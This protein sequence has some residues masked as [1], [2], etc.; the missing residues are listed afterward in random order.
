MILKSLPLT[1]SIVLL[2]T[3]PLP[4]A[5]DGGDQAGRG[6]RM[7]FEVMDK[8]RDGSISRQEWRGSD[9]SFEV[10]DWNKD[11]QLS[12]PEVEVGGRRETPVEQADHQ[13]NRFERNVNWT[14]AGFTSLD[15]NRD[16]RLSA[17]E[18]H[19][20]QE[21]FRRVDRNRDGALSQ[22]EFVGSATED[23]DRG[24]SFDDLDDNNNGRV[25]RSEWHGGAEVF[26]RL[27]RNRDGSLSRFEVVGAEPAATDVW[28]QFGNLDSNRN[29]TLS[30]NEW[31]WS[32]GNFDQ[33]DANRDAV[34]SR[35]EFE[36]NPPHAAATNTA[37]QTIRVNARNR[38]TDGVIEVR[39]GDTIVFESSGTIV[40]SDNQ[41]DTATPAGSRS[42][43]RA[44]D[45]PMLNQSAGALIAKIGDY[46]PLLVGARQTL[47]A[48]V[49]GRLY[50]GVNDD[51]LLDNS[52]EFT[53]SVKVHAT[54]ITRD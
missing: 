31:H 32:L 19:F 15:H 20:D 27:D 22:A 28:D 18:W 53:V 5:A 44:P 38:W 17:N 46:G 45:A 33:R 37:A 11:G 2:A 1:V 23:D 52:G 21:T 43:R 8:N 42:A 54:N 10:H 30:R 9:R 4:S 36:S 3:T 47:V 50:F 29:G 16:R 40:M 48:P 25:E 7:R 13:P 14:A 24:D 34:L 49:G 26:A 41:N 39:A 6:S 51:H 12:G 35:R